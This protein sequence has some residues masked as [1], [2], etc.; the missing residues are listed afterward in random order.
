MTSASL[1]RQLRTTHH[2]QHGPRQNTLFQSAG[3]PA[4]FHIRAPE[5]SRSRRCRTITKKEGGSVREDGNR[6]FMRTTHPSTTPSRPR[7]H[8]RGQRSAHSCGPSTSPRPPHSAQAR[9]YPHHASLRYD[10]LHHVDGL[11]EGCGRRTLQLKEQVVS[12]IVLPRGVSRGR[13]HAHERRVDE[14]DAL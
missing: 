12:D 5:A 9:T 2:L 7:L 10:I 1:P 14:L 4:E 8:T 13:C 11:S 6:K 3:C